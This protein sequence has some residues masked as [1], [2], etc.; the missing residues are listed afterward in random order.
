MS[1]D[2]A[3]SQIAAQTL[4]LI[5]QAERRPGAPLN[6]RVSEEERFRRHP[7]YEKLGDPNILVVGKSNDNCPSMP[8]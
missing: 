2:K 4:R 7:I 5:A 8:G 1:A 6:P 3:V